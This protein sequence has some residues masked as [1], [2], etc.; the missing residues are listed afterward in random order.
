[1]NTATASNLPSKKQWKATHNI[2]FFFGINAKILVKYTRIE[3]SITK[4]RTFWTGHI[5]TNRYFALFL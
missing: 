2:S 4:Q 1:M 5:V 3:D